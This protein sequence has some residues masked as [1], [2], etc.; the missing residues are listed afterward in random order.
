MVEKILIV[1]G[2]TIPRTA[3]TA[4]IPGI[5]QVQVT[6]HSASILQRNHIKKHGIRVT[7]TIDSIAYPNAITLKL[8]LSDVGKLKWRALF[9]IRVHVV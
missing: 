4:K 7:I 8:A 5:R 6:L 1:F 9:F 3:N 2:R